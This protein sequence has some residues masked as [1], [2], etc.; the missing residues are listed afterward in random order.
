MGR[1]EAPKEAVK[2]AIVVP[3]RD[4]YEHLRKFLSVMRDYPMP[5]KHIYVVEQQG[6]SKFN[7]GKLCNVGFLE[8]TDCTHVVFHDV[9]MIP[10][11]VDYSPANGVTQLATAATQFGEKLPYPNYL[12]GVV[13]FDR[14]TFQEING[15]SNEFWGWGLEDD[16]LS[17]RC[18]AK[19]VRITP[20]FGGKHISL[21]HEKSEGPSEES[22]VKFT[23][24]DSSGLSD[25]NYVVSSRYNG[26]NQTILKVSI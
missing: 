4:R 17:A 2:I 8:A 14:A 5:E 9:D 20:R 21:D 24:G 10:E 3:Y 18:A 13:M 15:F 19:H 6:N 26:S 12:G 25:C 7:R 23:H 16:D 11:G 22:L 1:E